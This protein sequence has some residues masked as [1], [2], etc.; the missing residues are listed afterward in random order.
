MNNKNLII[1]ILVAAL[2]AVS[3]Y[4][5]DQ[6]EETLGDKIDNVAEEIEDAV[7]GNN[8]S[9]EEIVEEVKDEIDDATTGN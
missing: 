8:N 1:A 4:A 5:F 6:R 2:L 9:A 3:I 7:D